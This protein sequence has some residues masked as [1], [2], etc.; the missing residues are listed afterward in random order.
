MGFSSSAS[1]SQGPNQTVPQEPED[2]DEE[3]VIYL[4]YNKI[5]T[6]QNIDTLKR[7]I[8]DAMKRITHM[9]SSENIMIG[10]PDGT[11]KGYRSGV[12]TYS[13]EVTISRSQDPEETFEGMKK[14]IA[15][16]IL[17]G[18]LDNLL[19]V[20]DGTVSL[21]DIFFK[22]I[23]NE[24]SNK[25]NFKFKRGIAEIK[26]KYPTGGNEDKLKFAT[27][28]KTILYNA[29]KSNLVSEQSE[30]AKKK[31]L[32]L[33]L[34]S[35]V[36]DDDTVVLIQFM[37]MDSFSEIEEGYDLAKALA[38]SIDTEKSSILNASL[39]DIN[40]IDRCYTFDTET[41]CN[42]STKELGKS[43]VKPVGLQKDHIVVINNNCKE[44][45][46]NLRDNFVSNAPLSTNCEEVIN[47]ELGSDK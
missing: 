12:C 41:P 38:T 16:S 37:I 6:V 39:T 8:I 46:K 10:N 28:I 24:I 21:R 17:D 36:D 45:V 32:Q 14:H 43:G 5:K 2:E 11:D 3:L 4:T 42:A 9:N 22:G 15:D 25:T 19:N 30:S 31:R 13:I 7:L 44:V 35:A 26:E 23:E 33:E 27:K 20:M 34:I 1:G 18:S 47:K 40:M 29:I